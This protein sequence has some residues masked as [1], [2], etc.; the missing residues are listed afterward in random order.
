MTLEDA[1]IK[2]LTKHIK[3]RGPR[4]VIRLDYKTV[5]IRKQGSKTTVYKTHVVWHV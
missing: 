1:T 5:P 4:A 3:R 2:R